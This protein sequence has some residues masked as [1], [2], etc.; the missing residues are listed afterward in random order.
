M[1]DTGFIT[2]PLHKGCI[3]VLTHSEYLRA[4]KRGKLQR[5]REAN[6]KR[7]YGNYRN[8]ASEGSSANNRKKRDGSE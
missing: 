6:E 4:L 3:L 5:Q 1:T 8:V 2:V 7:C